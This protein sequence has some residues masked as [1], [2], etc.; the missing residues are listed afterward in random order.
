[1]DVTW[2]LRITVQQIAPRAS[3]RPVA[4]PTSVHPQCDFALRR[5]SRA[6]Q[7]AACLQISPNNF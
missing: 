3:D 6:K 2:Q 4:F 1:M 7:D 5:E